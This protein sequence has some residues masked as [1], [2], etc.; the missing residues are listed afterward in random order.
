M[1][2]LNLFLSNEFK[3]PGKRILYTL[4]EAAKEIG[5]SKATISRSI[6]KGKLSAKKNDD[7]TY[8]IEP[9]ELQRWFD[10]NGRVNGQS[11]RM[12]TPVATH[13]TPPDNKAL[14]AEV[15]G[16]RAQVDL[17]KSE[18]DDLRSRL[19]TEGEERRKLTAMITDQRSHPEPPKGFWSR[20]TGR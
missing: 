6:K 18:R 14:Q 15:D 1:K 11:K 8:S 19:D 3:R 16:L 9:S 4:G 7:N 13:E 12:A 2:R 20:L 10:S 17:L 5:V